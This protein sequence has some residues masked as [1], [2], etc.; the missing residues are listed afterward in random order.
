MMRILIQLIAIWFVFS[1]IGLYVNASVAESAEK[2]WLFVSLLQARKIVSF[3]RDQISGALTRRMETDCPAEP[4]IMTL[5]PNRQFLFVALRSSGQI[6]SFRVDGNTGHL[7]LL[8]VAEGGADPAYLLADGHGRF[9]LSVY[10]EANQVCVHTIDPSGELSQQP[11]QTIPTAEKAHGLALDSANRIVLVPHTGSN[12][13]YQ[14]FFDSQS[15]RLT[16]AEPPYTATATE[17]HPRHITVHPTDRWAYANNEAGDSLGVY[18][19][20]LSTARLQRI[21]TVKTIP[22]TFDGQRNSTARCEMTRDGRFVYV[23]N[24]GHDSVAA[25]SIDQKTG[26]IASLGQFPTEKTPRSLTIEPTTRF[27]Y[28]AG[29]D[30][31]K[32]AAYRVQSTGKLERFATYEAGPVAWCVLAANLPANSAD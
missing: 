23:A 11:L 6:A 32:I 7:T 14:F 22:D 21:Q 3:E 30:S 15:G 19:V 4:A 17:D 2:S 28:A 10:Y 29:Q 31:G 18:T 8:S 24:R 9:L 27:L 26:Q 12:R 1:S 5:A 25:F 20:D 13:I 16:A